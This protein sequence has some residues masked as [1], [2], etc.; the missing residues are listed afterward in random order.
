VAEIGSATQDEGGA[1]H[2]TMDTSLL[3]IGCAFD[4][5]TVETELRGFPARGGAIFADTSEIIAFDCSFSDNGGGIGVSQGGAVFIEF[6][7]GGFNDPRAEFFACAFER[8]TATERGGAVHV[9]DPVAAPGDGVFLSEC[10]FDDNECAGEARGDEQ[11]GG[12][13]FG[14]AQA[15]GCTFTN[16]SARFGGL[17]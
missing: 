5:N 10:H 14:P 16:N 15:V 2:M 6:E 1:I 3:A 12:A 9:S 4:D 11:R 13:V 8:N 17:S 7:G